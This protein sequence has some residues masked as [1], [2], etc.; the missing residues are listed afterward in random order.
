[1]M[2]IKLRGASVPLILFGGRMIEEDIYEI[3]NSNYLKFIFFIGV[4]FSYFC[5]MPMLTI[6]LIWMPILY[7]ASYLLFFTKL[8]C[9][10]MSY[11][12]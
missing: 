2:L 4:V 6:M 8:E 12:R 3:P 11:G 7:I 9:E 1:M 10:K 5:F